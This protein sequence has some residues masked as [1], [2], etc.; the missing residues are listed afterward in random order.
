MFAMSFDEIAAILGRSTQAA[1]MLASRARQRVRTAKT[2]DPDPRP[3]HTVVQAFLAASRN[4]DFAALLDLL[5]PDVTAR[6]D[7][8]PAPGATPTR[9]R[10]AHVVARQALAFSHRAA[11]ARVGS[12][13]GEPAI[14]VTPHGRL[15]TVLTFTIPHRLIVNIDIITDPHRLAQLT[16]EPQP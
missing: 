14:L 13:N 3:R 6:A 10:G 9:L 11:H 16:T 8:Y 7:A 1:K 5:D 2:P 4:G 15:T 12:V